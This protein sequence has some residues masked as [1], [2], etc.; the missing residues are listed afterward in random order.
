M[1]TL[2]LLAAVLA[3]CEGNTRHRD[4]SGVTAAIDT[5]VGPVPGPGE[6]SQANPN[7]YSDHDP[8][9]IEDGYRLFQHYNCAGCHG[10]H[11]GGG[12]GPSLRDLDWMYGDTDAL[13]FD[14]IT[15][16]RGHGMPAWG[17]KLP[18][19][20]VWKLVVYIR[21]LRTAQEPDKPAIAE[22]IRAPLEGIK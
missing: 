1:R 6:A 20:Q 11:A 16:G 17:T 10:D 7:P 15:E 2:L 8:V 21:S 3:A 18:E 19:D 22:D 14:S 12:M 4:T 9:V 5:P 13:I